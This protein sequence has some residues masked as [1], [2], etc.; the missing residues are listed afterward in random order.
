MINEHTVFQ[1]IRARIYSNKLSFFMFMRVKCEFIT[2]RE[3]KRKKITR[4][5][6]FYMCN[7]NGQIYIVFRE[8]A[9]M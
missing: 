6:G 7:G 8:T 3:F 2:R 9:N 4:R 1:K 5:S